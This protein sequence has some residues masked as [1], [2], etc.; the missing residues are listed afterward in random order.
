MKVGYTEFSFGYAFT[1]N[2]IRSSSAAPVGAPVFP[3]LIQ[4]GHSGFDIRINFGVPLFFQYK[5]PE[6]MKRGTAFE[7]ASGHCPGL[8]IPFFR[9]AMMRRDVSRQHELLL[10]LEAR[11]PSNVFYAAPC[12]ANIS[13]FDRS[14][15]GATVARQSIFVS[16]GDIGPL[17]DDKAHS[18]AQTWTGNWIFLL[19]PKPPKFEHLMISLRSLRSSSP[20]SVLRKSA[21]RRVRCAK[22][23]LSLLRR[24]CGKP[25]SSLLNGSARYAFR[26]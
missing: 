15:N 14:Y 7:I 18:L 2:L 20:R 9:I 10:R 21:R 13:D 16:P 25:N 5:L 19:E 8:S 23:Y 6:L 22:T 3:N 4:E 26:F 17:P 12:I 11:Y 24:Q 1:E